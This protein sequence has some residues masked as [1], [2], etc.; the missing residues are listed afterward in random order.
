M[1]ER[2]EGDGILCAELVV[3]FNSFRPSLHSE[4]GFL[5][6]AIGNRIWLLG[7]ERGGAV[8]LEFTKKIAEFALRQKRL[9][10][11]LSIVQAAREPGRSLT[12][13]PRTACYSPFLWIALAYS[14]A[15]NSNIEIDMDSKLDP[16]LVSGS[17]AS[18]SSKPEYM[19]FEIYELALIT[20]RDNFFKCLNKRVT[21]VVLK[22]IERERNG[23]TINTRL[24]SRVS[25]L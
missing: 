11:A 17:I 3:K 2:V 7:G 23:E 15:H 19:M 24:V 16:G 12:L 9:S 14:Y 25:D 18:H 10:L 4:S 8:R 5:L 1:D 6:R 21:N 22:L 20:W 13:P